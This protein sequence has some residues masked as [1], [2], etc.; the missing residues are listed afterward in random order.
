MASGG[1][2]IFN[3]SFSGTGAQLDI[4]TPGFKPRR[5]DLLNVGG[6]CQAV[7]TESM[8]DASMQKIV[9]SG[10]GTTDITFVTTN[11]VTPLVDGFRLGADAD[12]NVSAEKV[13]FT[14]HE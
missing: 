1:T 6:N 13:H 5:V 9:D 11:G 12:I 4:T 3:G 10:G 7:W 14:A 2:R 8:A